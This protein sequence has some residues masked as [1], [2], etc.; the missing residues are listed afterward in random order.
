[1]RSVIIIGSIIA[2][3]VGY[4]I[5]K[6]MY[7]GADWA[8]WSCDKIELASVDSPDQQWQAKAIQFG[9]GDGFASAD[10]VTV[11]VAKRNHWWLTER[12]EVFR[13]SSKW[14]CGGKLEWPS[15]GLLLVSIPA[16]M[17][18]DEATRPAANV[19]VKIDTVPV[20]D[21]I[22]REDFS[23]RPMASVGTY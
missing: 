10:W 4:H 14:E 2:L 16:N 19:A 8:N 18:I 6:K 9:C 21:A 22:A 3:L 13:G 23:C 1:M 15:N 17:A 12:D 7:L 20:D 5:G 11:V